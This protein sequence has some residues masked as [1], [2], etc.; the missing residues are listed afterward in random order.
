MLTCDAHD[1]ENWRALEDLTNFQV[2]GHLSLA[3][4]LRRRG[5]SVLRCGSY[6]FSSVG[7]I[8]FSET[9]STVYLLA[10]SCFWTLTFFFSP[11]IVVFHNSSVCFSWA[12]W[13]L[14]SSKELTVCVFLGLQCAC[15]C[16]CTSNP[17]FGAC[18]GEHMFYPETSHMGL[19]STEPFSCPH[20]RVVHHL[21]GLCEVVP[22]LL[23]CG[24]HSR[25]SMNI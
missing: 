25:P 3:I 4:R 23:Q 20:L 14:D 2:Q 10:R 22:V 7:G 12:L 6:R 18:R 8:F 11:C 13:G 19:K 17:G 15:V 9:K 16:S 1:S 5:S 21:L 24:L